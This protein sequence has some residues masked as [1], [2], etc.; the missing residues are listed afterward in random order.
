MGQRCSL[1][2]TFSLRTVALLVLY[3]SKTCMGHRGSWPEFFPLPVPSGS[4]SCGGDVTVYVWHKPTH[5][6]HSFLFCSSVYFCLM[7]LSTVFHS[8]NSPENSPFSNFVLPVLPLPYLFM[9]VSFSPAIIPSGWLGS[10]HQLILINSS[11][12][13]ALMVLFP[14]KNCFRQRSS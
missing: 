1:P 14:S 2:E 4:P 11:A 6:A 10:K 12:N 5:P 8:I 9:K 13:F 7:A 3:L